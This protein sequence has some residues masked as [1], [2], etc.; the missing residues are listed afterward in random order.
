MWEPFVRISLMKDNV[1]GKQLMALRLGAG[2]SQRAL[3]EKLGFSNQTVSC[4]EIG[5]NE[6]DLDCLVKIAKF[7]D[8]SVDELLGLTD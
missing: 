8:V 3:G 1:F 4:W 5:R 2:I 6:P 7:F